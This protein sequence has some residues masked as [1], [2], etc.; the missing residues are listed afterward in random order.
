MDYCTL[1]PAC[2]IVRAL[3]DRGLD[4][5]RLSKLMPG[6][7]SPAADETYPPEL[8]H[9]EG[10]GALCQKLYGVLFVYF[11]HLYGTFPNN[12]FNFLHTNMQMDEDLRELLRVWKWDVCHISEKHSSNISPSMLRGCVWTDPTRILSLPVVKVLRQR[13]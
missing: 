5:K 11:Q 3:Q 2:T 4:P 8:M 6:R 7:R 13:G 12:L 1:G 9:G 10:Y